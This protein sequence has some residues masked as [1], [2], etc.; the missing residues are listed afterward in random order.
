[1]TGLGFSED[2][3]K[4]VVYGDPSGIGAPAQEVL[5]TVSVCEP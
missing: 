1:V 3:K 5:T 2:I 4:L